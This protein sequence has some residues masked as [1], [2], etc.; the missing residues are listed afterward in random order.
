M[1]DRMMMVTWG[2]TVTGRE[3]HALEVFNDSLGLYGQLQQDGKIE[4]F[5]VV[6]MAP[7][8]LLS[9]YATL[10]GSASQM[11]TVRDD[12]A[13]RRLCIDATL[14]VEDFNVIDGFCDEGVADELAMFQ[15]AIGKVPQSA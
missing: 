15:E 10:K 9:G 8:P 3:E 2:T 1:A 14:M 5:D 4:S 12:A 7:N 13:F 6:L 11:A